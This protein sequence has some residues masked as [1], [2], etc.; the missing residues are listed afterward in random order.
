MMMT[1]QRRWSSSNIKTD[2]LV[3]I[4]S[5]VCC[6]QPHEIWE[7]RCF[8]FLFAFLS[9]VYIIFLFFL[10]LSTSLFD[11]LFDCLYNSFNLFKMFFFY[12]FHL[13]RFFFNVI[14][15]EC[16]EG[17]DIR[18]LSGNTTKNYHLDWKFWSSHPI[19]RLLVYQTVGHIFFGPE[20]CR[21][22][23]CTAR[24]RKTVCIEIVFQSKLALYLRN[25]LTS[26]LR[27]NRQTPLVSGM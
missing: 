27:M 26:Q 4:T 15:I 21:S 9:L 11:K 17:T 23:R 7:T 3:D 20:L 24:E 13:V 12:P 18:P 2:P 8:A 19:A 16:S 5:F 1:I 6:G 25:F 14:G 10:G 22:R